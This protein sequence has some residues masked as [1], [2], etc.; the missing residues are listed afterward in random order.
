LKLLF[1]TLLICICANL[2]AQDINQDI[3]TI[4]VKG[5]TFNQVLS[6][7]AKSGYSIGKLDNKSKTV[8]TNFLRYNSRTSSIN[9]SIKVHVR[10]SV[11]AIT[12]KMC[13]N[14][15][16]SRDGIPDSARALNIRYTFG[17]YKEAFLQMDQFARSL[18]PEVIYSKTYL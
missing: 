7:L 4:T 5:I 14:M 17:T 2:F 18:K 1:L 9:I 3:N 10:D 13:Y 16:N 12:G 11:A 8:Q 15:N 6:H